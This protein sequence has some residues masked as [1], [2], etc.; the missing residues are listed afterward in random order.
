M[1]ITHLEINV[2]VYLDSNLNPKCRECGSVSV[3]HV[4]KT[5]FGCLVCTKCKDE[6]PEKYSLL[7]KTECKEVSYSNFSRRK[8]TNYMSLTSRITC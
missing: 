1:S 8:N 6:H 3:D 4:Y 7:T 5:I 2:A